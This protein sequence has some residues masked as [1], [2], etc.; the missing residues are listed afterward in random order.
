[1]K[2]TNLLPVICVGKVGDSENGGSEYGELNSTAAL[3]PLSDKLSP[4]T[5]R[6]LYGLMATAAWAGAARAAVTSNAAVEIQRRQ[7]AVFIIAML[8]KSVKNSR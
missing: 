1:M 5:N 4:N 7:D 6:L 3:F 2:A 8:P